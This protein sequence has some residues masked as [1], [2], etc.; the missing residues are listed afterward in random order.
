[1]N[2]NSNSQPCE[3]RAAAITI[4]IIIAATSIRPFTWCNFSPFYYTY[5]YIVLRWNLHLKQYRADDESVSYLDLLLRLMV[6][7]CIWHWWYNEH[8]YLH[9]LSIYMTQ[10][11]YIKKFHMWFC[12]CCCWLFYSIHAFAFISNAMEEIL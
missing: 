10:Y 3:K 4:I 9:V 11:L 8:M 1:M 7:S 12:C 6:L 5:M 2:N